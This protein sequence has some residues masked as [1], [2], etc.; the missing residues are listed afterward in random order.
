MLFT[1]V[2][3]FTF[4]EPIDIAVLANR[5]VLADNDNGSVVASR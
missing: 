5:T 3:Q 2:Q 4:A 1:M